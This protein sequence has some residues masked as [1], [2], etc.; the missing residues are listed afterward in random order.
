MANW[1]ITGCSSGLGRALA[2]EALN[3]GHNVVVTA[4]NPESVSN[5]VRKHPSSAMAATLDVRDRHQ[6]QSAVKVARERFGT[7]D[8]LVNNA[9]HG[10][11]A[12]VEEG[13]TDE[14]S[15]LFD[16]NFSGPVALIKEV[17]PSMR[18]RC[19][20]VIVNVSTIAVPWV[21]AGS[22]YYAASKAALEA[23]S[24][25]LRVELQPLGIKVLVIEP[26]GF[27][28]DF[29]GR[30]LM[31]SKARVS[32]YAGTAGLRRKDVDPTHGR[33]P[34][35][36]AR[37]ARIIVEAINAESLPSRLLLGSDAVRIVSEHLQSRL[38]ETEKWASLSVQT[39][40]E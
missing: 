40:F 18:E 10:Y 37:A 34:G 28:T 32:A 27:R 17:L 6:I 39:D 30:S 31:E 1:L 2:L 13:D 22:G 14:V 3:Q 15:A 23:V 16:A 4:R 24:D 12:A 20:G 8:V 29:A 7:I 36:P 25:A 19:S 35:D 21:P 33:Q 11:R 9:G 38:A 5:V 26:G